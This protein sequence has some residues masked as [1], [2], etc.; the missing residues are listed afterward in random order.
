MRAMVV[1]GGP[2][3][4]QFVFEIYSRPEQHLIYLI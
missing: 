1:E 2:E 3:L 4:E